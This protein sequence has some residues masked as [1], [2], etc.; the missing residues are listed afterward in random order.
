MCMKDQSSVRLCAAHTRTLPISQ[1][2]TQVTTAVEEPSNVETATSASASST[3]DKTADMYTWSATITTTDTKR[4]L[5]ATDTFTLFSS[6]IV[7]CQAA[8]TRCWRK[9]APSRAKGLVSATSAIDR[10]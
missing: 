7:F 2:F 10:D 4:Y 3:A 5:Y 9:A 6:S 1:P 8:P